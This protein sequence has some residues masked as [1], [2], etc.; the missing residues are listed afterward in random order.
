MLSARGRPRGQVSR[1][2]DD[3]ARR[4]GGLGPAQVLVGLF[5]CQRF[6][7]GMI[8]VL[9]VP[10]AL[11]VL[12]IGEPGIGWLTAAVGLGGLAGGVVALTLV[13]R[14]LLAGAFLAGLFAWG[15]GIL[16]GGAVPVTVVALVALS[17][18][19][20][21]KVVVDV[22]GYSLL[23]RTVPAAARSSVFGL[24]EGLIAASLAAGSVLASLLIQLIGPTSALIAA[25]AL[26]IVVGIAAWPILRSVD[27]AAVV[28]ENELRLLSSVAM[29]RPLQL[30]TIEQLAEDLRRVEVAAGEVVIRQGDPGDAFYI[31]EAGR[32]QAL[33]DGSP[34]AELDPGESFGEIALVRDVPRTATVRAL[35]PG[36]LAVL[37]RQPFLAAITSTGESSA[38]AESVIHTRL[39]AG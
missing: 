26:P 12:R 25:G 28:P 10:A 2:E 15:A 5:V 23:Q 38:A 19:G 27:Q 7:R 8:T 36:V 32:L 34:T 24:L 3:L 39:T 11:E 16:A 22:A 33:V 1:K 35:E 31:V 4:F 14:R 13:G 18:A 30:T 6:V 29:F 9:I 20:I 37:D 21:G 17:V